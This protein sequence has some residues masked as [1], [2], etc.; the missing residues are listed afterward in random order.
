[1]LK[2]KELNSLHSSQTN[3]KKFRIEE[4]QPTAISVISVTDRKMIEKKKL[5]A[6]EN[7]QESLN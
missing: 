3:S 1:M 6:L 5:A 2:R 4:N 7:R